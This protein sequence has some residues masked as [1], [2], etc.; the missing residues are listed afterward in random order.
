MFESVFIRALS[1]TP[2][3][4]SYVRRCLND[5]NG[6]HGGT[7]G[8]VVNMEIT[9]GE[10]GPVDEYGVD[11]DHSVWHKFGPAEGIGN[12]SLLCLSDTCR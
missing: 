2:F 5:L 4:S 8:K 9:D 6:V 12:R 3:S 1:S 7:T 10:E 11:K